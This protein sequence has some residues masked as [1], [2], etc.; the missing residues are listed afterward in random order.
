[1]RRSRGKSYLREGSHKGKKS[2][3]AVFEKVQ[4]RA[5]T[6]RSLHNGKI[7]KGNVFKI[8]DYGAL[9]DIGGVVGFIHISEISENHERKPTEYLKIGQLYDFKVI[10]I[11]LNKMGELSTKLTRKFA[12]QEQL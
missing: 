1:M 3:S 8:L 7:I 9:V 6:I 12:A 5:D 11:G 2:N 10:E 4:E